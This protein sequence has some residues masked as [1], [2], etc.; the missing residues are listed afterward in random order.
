MEFADLGIKEQKGRQ[1][2]A[3]I[4]PECDS[5]RTKHQGAKCLTVNDEVGNRWYRCS[6]CS[7]SGNI[8]FQGRYDAVKEK[9]KI[10]TTQ[11][12][13][14]LKVREYFQKRGITQ[15]TAKKARLYEMQQ[16]QRTI[17]CFPYFMSLTL[18]NV[19]YLNMDWTK[20]DKG[21]KWFQLPKDLGTRIIPFGLQHIKTHDEEGTKFPKNTLIITEGEWDML[22]YMECGYVNVISVPQGAPSLNSKNFDKEF[23]YLQDKYVVSVLADIDLIYLSVDN[24]EPGINLRGHLAMILGKE[25]C[26]VIRYP[27]GYKDINEVFAGD[28]K[29]GL[30]ALG[31]TGVDEC[32]SNS[33]SVPIKGVVKASHVREDLDMLRNQGFTKGLGCGVPEVDYLF[34]V[35]PKLITFIT[36]VPGCFTGEQLIH[37][38]KGVLQIKD[39]RRG[40]YVLTYDHLHKINEYRKVKERHHYKKH[41]GKLYRITLKDGTIIKVT[42]NHKFFTGVEYVQVRE[43]IS[44]F[45][46]KSKNK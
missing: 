44:M 41:Q 36:G 45:A 1:R 46:N 18:V 32:L 22:T 23:A 35:K 19:K 33:S 31:K 25:K 17:I 43:I 40:D 21:P 29:K 12:A 27:P 2:Y 26:K 28:E 37:T 30:E 16:G 10:P 39:I 3:T 9:S 13:F 15:N 7:W 8:D 34:T 42:E 4:C 20:G 11:K 5:T 6:H 24:D 38:N 14:S